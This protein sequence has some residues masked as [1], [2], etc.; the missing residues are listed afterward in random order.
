MSTTREV[1]FAHRYR[2]F[3][4]CSALLAVVLL[5]P[6]HTASAQ[7]QAADPAPESPS[8]A[9][10]SIYEYIKAHID[11]ATGAL[12]AEAKALPDEPATRR[13]SRLRWVPGALEGLGTRHMQWDGSEK[14][15]RVT[16]VLEQ[17]AAGDSNAEPV[18][19]D[20]LRT[21]DVV[22]YYSDALDFASAR[23]HDIEPVMHD[24]ARR[25][26]TTS[27]DRGPVKF[28]IAMLGA[29]GDE[30]DLDIVQTLALHDEFGLYAAEAIGEI[31]PDRQRSLYDMARRLN[32]WGR[33]EAVTKMVATSNPPLRRW[34]LT[35]GFHN[36]I[37]AQY[38][39]YQCVT[40]ADLAGALEESP[41]GRRSDTALLVGAADLIQTLIKPGPGRGFDNYQDAPQA[42]E[43]F[44]QHIQKRRDSV[45]FYLAAN[46]LKDYA[47]GD[48]WTA[49]ERSRVV[50]LATQVASDKGWRRAIVAAVLDDRSNLDEA[51]LAAAKFGLSTI[52]L[53]VQRL[54]KNPGSSQR[55]VH[56][57]AAAS[58]DAHI[59]RLVVIAQRAFGGRLTQAR[60]VDAVA[61]SAALTAVL[62]GLARYPGSGMTLVEGSLGDGD[63]GVRRAAVETLVRWGGPYLRDTA[64]RT[65]L[66]DAARYEADEALKARMVALLNLG[67]M[68]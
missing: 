16:H 4:L 33:I 63:D 66:N 2:V 20:L 19:Y 40:I 48:H 36:D 60:H 10:P 55:W 62:Q 9:T 50:G 43:A 67:T 59:A 26:A 24:L 17:I 47:A 42:A 49:D 18:L 61:S 11:P 31:A 14:A 8:P 51:E 52:D 38:L 15:S 27:H 58:D 39:A 41:V 3:D 45:S 28:G 34:L 22:T 44:L 46:A 65:A 23:I 5:V 30:H 57:F 25:L 68:P 7:A 54:G 1:R 53:H 32:G 37:T 64:V 29:M 21:D 13:Y 56:A 35:E 6:M 12:A